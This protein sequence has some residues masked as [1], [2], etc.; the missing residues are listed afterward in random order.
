MVIYNAFRANDWRRLVMN[1][2]PVKLI[3]AFKDYLWGGT[4]LVKEYNKKTDLK[5]VAESWEL[6][7]HKNGESVIADGEFK[8]LTLSEYL[9]KN[10]DAIGKRAAEFD[11]FPIL[12][13]LLPS[14]VYN[15]LHRCFLLY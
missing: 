3:P 15:L 11:F 13:K 4:R 5:I 2:L 14:K 6:S 10:S 7:T 12:I 9:E 8:G 1:K